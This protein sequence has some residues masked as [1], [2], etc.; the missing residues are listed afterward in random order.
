MKKPDRTI[1]LLLGD[2]QRNIATQSQTTL[3]TQLP[4]WHQSK[5]TADKALA[6]LPQFKK[7]YDTICFHP[8]RTSMQLKWQVCRCFMEYLGD[9]Q[10]K[11]MPVNKLMQ[12]YRG[13]VNELSNLLNSFNSP[14]DNAE[15]TKELEIMVK[16]GLK[17][18]FDRLKMQKKRG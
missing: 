13:H 6:M 2:T 8:N 14:E 7:E 4:I 11:K 17:A 10:A 15:D 12:F 5:R 9:L 18:F 16:N 1:S 3:T